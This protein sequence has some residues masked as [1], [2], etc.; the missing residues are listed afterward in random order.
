L[1]LVCYAA[2][3]NCYTSDN[4]NLFPSPKMAVAS[5]NYSWKSPNAQ[6]DF[7]DLQD[8]FSNFSLFS[9]LNQSFMSFSLNPDWRSIIIFTIKMR[10]WGSQRL[11]S[12]P[13]V[14]AT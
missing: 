5:H 8:V 13:K 9:L 1:G 4:P 3:S 12:M 2:V 10:N 14:T 11:R 6:F 7:S